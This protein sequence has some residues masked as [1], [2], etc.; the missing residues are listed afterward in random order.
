MNTPVQSQPVQRMVPGQPRANRGNGASG[1][2]SGPEYGTQP[3]GVEASINWA[4]VAQTAIPI[5]SGL[6]GLF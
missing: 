5:I 6:A 2:A 3:S 1:P 4:Q